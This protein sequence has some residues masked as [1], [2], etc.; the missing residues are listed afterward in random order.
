MSSYVNCSNTDYFFL[1]FMHQ[2]NRNSRVVRL[3]GKKLADKD[4]GGFGQ[5]YVTDDI[6]PYERIF[7]PSGITGLKT[8]QRVCL[9]GYKIPFIV[10]VYDTPRLM[11]CC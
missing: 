6:H 9:P 1:G 8:D 5:Y 2:V 3:F 4:G 10:T 11:Y 7:L